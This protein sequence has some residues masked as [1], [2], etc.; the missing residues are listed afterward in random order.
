MPADQDTDTRQIGNTADKIV[1]RSESVVCVEL[2]A[3]PQAKEH[4]RREE[5]KVN[6]IENNIS[7][8]NESLELHEVDEPNK[9][10]EGQPK[11][12]D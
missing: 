8:H 7:P 4:L 5:E 9:Y 1:G 11:G 6:P 3:R 12:P 10:G 2:S